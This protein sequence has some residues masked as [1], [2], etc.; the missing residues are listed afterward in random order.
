MTQKTPL[1]SF[2]LALAATPLWSAPAHAQAS[3]PASF[4]DRLARELGVSGGLTAEDLATRAVATSNTVEARRSDV[5]SA[6]ATAS[7]ASDGYIPKLTVTA[8]YT[9]L[10]DLGTN[11][12]GSVVVAPT[13]PSGVVN[14]TTDLLV[15]VPQNRV[16]I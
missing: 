10:S 15:S 16:A 5:A 9:R 2:L 14:P 4:E 8:R 11:S 12:A 3:A 13:V 1:L 6:N 7:R